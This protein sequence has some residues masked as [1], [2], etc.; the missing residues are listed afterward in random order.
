M[1][2]QL[3]VLFLAASLV[4][5]LAS[6]KQQPTNLRPGQ[7][8]AQQDLRGVWKI[9]EQ[10]SRTPGAAWTVAKPAHLSVYIFTRAHYSYMWTP[11]PRVLFAGDPNRPTDAEKAAAYSSFIAASGTYVL[12]G[13]ALTLN[14]IM[15]KNPNEMTGVPLNY[16]VEIGAATLQMTITNPPFAPG[17]ERRTVLTRLE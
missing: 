10:S 14:A 9:I 5:G 16:A 2:G 11:G 1:S 12:T 8:P 13:S 6:N 3:L 7:L 17:Q 15:T 4:S